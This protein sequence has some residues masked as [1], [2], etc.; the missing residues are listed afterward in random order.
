VTMF[1]SQWLANA[2]GATYEID[3]SIRFN[4]D[5][6]AY[7]YRDNTSAQTDTKK[8]TYSVWI[9]KGSVTGGTN[10]GLLS[11]GSG[12]TSGRSDFTFTAGAATGDSTNDAL[13]FDIYT[14][15]W[16]Q[17]RT[18]AL[19][20][21]PSAW[22]HIVLVYDAA[23]GTVNDTLIVYQNGTR[24]AL[25]S[26]SGVPNNLS[27][28]NANS[29]RT[30]VGADASGTPVEFDGYMAEI[31]MIDGQALAPTSFGE[32]NDDG[33]WIPKAYSGSYGTNG[34]YIDGATSTFLGKDAKATSAAVTNKASTSS[35]WGGTTGAYTFATNEIDRSSTVNG[36]I[37]TD[38]LSGDFSFDFT[39]TSAG[40]AL[41]VGVIDDQEFNTFNGTGDDGGMDS[42]TNSWY[43]DKGNNQFRYGGAS[44][45]SA[46][47]IAN[48]AAVTIER[49]GSTIKITDDGSDA[50]TFSQTFS[51]PVRVV[52]SGGGA[53]FNLDSV[54]YTADGASGNDNSY[55]S[56]G[57]T[58]ADQM[59]DTPTLNKATFN[60]LQSGVG[61]TLSDGN[62]VDS[63]S[64]T[65][66]FWNRTMATQSLTY[67]TYWE[68]HVD[69]YYALNIGISRMDN[70][71]T[72]QN[73]PAGLFGAGLNNNEAFVSGSYVNESSGGRT[74]PVANGNYI[75]LAYDPARNALWM[76]N[77][78]TWKDGTGSSASSSTILSEIEGSGTSY[79]IFT[80]IGTEPV[81]FV[82]GYSTNKCTAR[83]SSEDWEGTVPTGYEELS[84]AFIATP[85]ITDGSAHFQT[86]L[87]T[88]NGS[89]LE[90][91]Q[92]G[93]STFQP[94][95]LWVKSRSLGA[96]GNHVSYDAVRGVTNEIYPNLTNAEGATNAL[97]S[98]D[99]NGFTLQGASSGSE[100][101]N[102]SGATYVGW[103]WAAN[104]A[105]SSNT[106][107]SLSS[108]VSANQTAGFS[109]V[110]ATPGIVETADTIGH[111]LGIA[112]KMIIG[113][114][115]NLADNWHVYHSAISP[116][117][118]VRLN[119]TSAATTSSW[120]SAT[121]SSVFQIK[122]GNW[123]NG[124]QVC[125][126]Y[127]FAEIPG[128]SSIGSY[129]GNSSTNGT[130][131]YTGFK[132]A[133]VLTKNINTADQWGIR[134]ATRNPHNVTDFLINPN[135][136]TA[137]TSSS[138]GYIDIL[139]NGFK[140]RSADSNINTQTMIYMAFAEHPFG[141]DGVAPATAR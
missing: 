91:N 110:T 112:P 126:F 88:G 44:Q 69:T 16:T 116:A 100:R 137:E 128:F 29:Q 37:S 66:G 96:G 62:L 73:A 103:Q 141:G 32:F 121:T 55:F 124:G 39:M 15:G 2:G 12:T 43:L 130:F 89:A 101:F 125:L 98:F 78:G 134:D 86:T 94:D 26:T 56:S 60:P 63:M 71:V 93:N 9:K 108:T 18:T 140:P 10:V 13:K 65:S 38:L 51:G 7:L 139:S 120:Q 81:P 129:T 30:K 102:K 21:D 79:A 109:I 70:S 5:D 22:Y 19:L 83:F 41:R 59:L 58:T 117:T 4:D 48:G 106:D 64:G 119:T 82:G 118:E 52:I 138:T 115:T 33:V 14:G 114:N 74:F 111:G 8:F 77:E 80:G 17:R 27:L 68:I 23:N 76:G 24:L 133:F 28:V 136:D 132:P 57:L 99:A 104:G 72:G 34:F 85:S 49:T 47:G 6:A 61:Q 45:G 92:A 75:M 113:K 11:G 20:R 25:D 87:Y 127:C 123:T 67:K 40:G 3:Q 105:G 35:E 97:T 31:N 53:A 42:M 54:Q 107:G 131:I 50:H 122:N 135:A 46:S 90:V 36:I 84:T 95:W 1:G